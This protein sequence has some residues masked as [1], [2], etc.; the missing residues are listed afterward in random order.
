MKKQPEKNFTDTRLKDVI[1]FKVPINVNFVSG[2]VTGFIISVFL[3]PYDRACYLKL[4]DIS[5]KKLLSPE[6]WGFSGLRYTIYQRVVC[7]SVYYTA[8]GELHSRFKPWMHQQ[9]YNPFFT[10]LSIGLVAG[11]TNC[12]FSNWICAIKFYS[13]KQ[14]PFKKPLHNAKDMWRDGGIYPF[15]KGTGAGCLRDSTFGVIYEVLNW[16]QDTYIL[17]DWNQSIDNEQIRKLTFFGSR[18]LSALPATAASSLFNYVRNMQFNSP[19]DKSQSRAMDI[20]SHI[21]E[22]S[23]QHVKNKPSF[24]ILAR[25]LFFMELLMVGAGT[26]RAALQIGLS[27]TLVDYL[28]GVLRDLD[29]DR[30]C[31]IQPEVEQVE[32]WS[33]QLNRR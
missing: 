28:K 1:H 3:H 25:T 31:D 20:L 30:G 12:I 26:L 22:Q 15:L 4:T 24:R 27:Q 10:H 23:N 13:F 19:P 17:N 9:G 2:V 14:E 21:W 16:A 11:V 18:S 29:M 6:Y 33:N 7:N 5:P 32:E 8:Q